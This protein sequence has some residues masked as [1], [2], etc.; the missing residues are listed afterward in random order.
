MPIDFQAG[1]LK[2][3][4]LTPLTGLGGVGDQLEM[5]RQS[6]E[7]M[8]QKFEETKKQN[9]KDEEYRRLSQAAATRREEL[10]NERERQQ[11]AAQAAAENL[12][13]RQAA[14]GEFNKQYNE[15]NLEGMSLAAHQLNQLGG[16]ARRIDA[17]DGGFPAWQVDL[18]PPKVPAGLNP[19]D[20]LGYGTLGTPDSLPETEAGAAPALST[21]EA[22][23]QAGSVPAE[24]PAAPTG[25]DPTTDAPDAL[26][27]EHLMPGGEAT[28]TYDQYGPP[29]AP[30]APPSAPSLPP[31]LQGLTPG[32]TSF[33]PRRAAEAPD[34][35]GGVTNDVPSDVVNTAALQYQRQQRLGPVMAS[36]AAAMPESLRGPT[37]QAGNAMLAAGLPPEKTMGLAQSARQ[38][39]AGAYEKE[40]AHEFKMQEEA[41]KASAP[42]K[43]T[44][45]QEIVQKGFTR[46]RSSAKDKKIPDAIGT[47]AVADEIEQMLTGASPLG[48]DR[49][50]NLLG[51]LNAQSKQQSDADANRLTGMDRASLV[52][53][54]DQYLYQ[55]T[56]SGFDDDVKA[57]MLEFVQNIREH[58]KVAVHD[59]VETVEKEAD[60]NSEPL[61]GRGMREYAHGLVGQRLLQEYDKEAGEESGGLTQVSDEPD[62]EG[63]TIPE[64]SR[65]A[66]VHNNPGNLK[67][68]GQQGAEQG[69]PAAGGGHWAK[70]KT[71]EDGVAALRSQIERDAK[72]GLS[73][74]EFVT[75]Y[76][77]PTDGNDTEAYIK[78]MAAALGAQEGDKLSGVDL[79]AAVRFVARKESSTELPAK[80]KAGKGTDDAE[81]LEGL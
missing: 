42:L 58:S 30:V 48:Q 19:M 13:Q 59:W 61:V 23:A 77:P 57:S 81:A 28:T 35:T 71:V 74:R 44:E 78:Q 53:K 37:E 64:T 34:M 67:F 6:L 62:D 46:A 33:A 76:A 17:G 55:I 41:A 18:E 52:A 12:K 36:M 65:I 21:E 45:E 22:F 25:G 73:V 14:L 10:I 29:Q 51:Q 68:A 15:G 50:I 7:L 27:S 38:E 60:S 1:L 26:T 11:A 72:A 49:A 20:S 31:S 3:N 47:F 32:M 4:P 2:L 24:A 43:R 5:E 54:V 70:F 79:D 40:Q 63:A 80:A 66:S 75:K 56:N 39:V 8:R 16:F 9:L 69:E